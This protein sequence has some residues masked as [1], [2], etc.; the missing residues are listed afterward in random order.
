M[1]VRQF[2]HAIVRPTL[3]ALDLHSPAAERLMLG[4]AAHE[5]DGLRYIRQ[6]GGGPALSFF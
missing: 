6:L 2:A 4:T 1:D 3:Y 5:S